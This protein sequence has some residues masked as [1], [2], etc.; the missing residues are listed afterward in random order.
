MAGEQV[1]VN[2]DLCGAPMIIRTGRR[3]RFLGCS[4]YPACRGTK[5]IKAAIEAG[6]QPPQPEKLDESC[7]EC[8]K[9]L[10][11]RT[12][13]KGKFI[14]CSGYPKCRYSRDLPKPEPEGNS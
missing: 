10:V 1:G 12:G 14:A 9:T 7:P 8:G 6:W 4:A 3:G 5:P 11:V 13:R 2:C